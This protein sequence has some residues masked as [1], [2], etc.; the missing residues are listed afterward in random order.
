[1][2][3]FPPTEEPPLRD[4]VTFVH[5][6]DLHLDAPFTGLSADDPTVGGDLAEATYRAFAGVVDVCLERDADFLVIAGD[7]YNSADRSFRAQ[8]RFRAE[9]ERLAEQEIEVFVVHGNHDPLGGWSAKLDMPPNVH[10]FP[11]DR[12]ERFEI[13]QEGELVAA[14]YGR[15]FGARA[16]A[17][18]LAL[19][20]RRQA[21]DPFAIG[22]LHANVGGNPDYDPYAPASLSDLRSLGLDYWAL[23][24]I[25]KQEVL[26]QDPWV[27][28]AGSP[29]GLNPR[30]TGIHGCIVVEVRGGTVMDAEAVDL[31]PVSWAQTEVDVGEAASLDDVRSRVID[32]CERLREAAGRPC[33]VRMTLVGR[34]GAHRDLVR[35]ACLQ[36]LAEDVRR[37]QAAASPWV[38]LDRLADRTAP[39]LD[40]DAVRKGGDFAAE[41]VTGGD[42]LAA[43]PGALEALIDELS[44]PLAAT[45]PGYRPGVSGA[46]LIVLAR[47]A[48][49]DLLL[50]EDEDVP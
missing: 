15:S 10:V 38:W 31:A 20:Y 3:S 13:V 41:V 45:L 29:Q 44:A 18:N 19:G 37:D 43:E 42:A 39:P 8:L 2:N 27:V 12:V 11:S 5:T 7:A 30:E 1:M 35:A 14:V 48:A 21:G 17:Q 4:G 49:L 50:A 47:D 32:E 46:D 28:Y 6:A 25:H 9:L 33:V 24:H 26:A 23:G 36:E 40:L 34:S 16:E 22:V